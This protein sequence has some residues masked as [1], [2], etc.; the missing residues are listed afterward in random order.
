MM[1]GKGDRMKLATTASNLSTAL[2]CLRG[3]IERRNTIPILGAVK[4]EA[5]K[6]VGTNLD[7]EAEV[8]LPC[9][10]KP[11]GVAAIDYFSLVRLAGRIDADETVTI[12]EADDLAS[13]AFNGSEYSLPSLSAADFPASRAVE[14]AR[15]LTHNA[16][17]VAAMRRVRFA[18]ST[19]ETRYYLNGVSI[20]NDGDGNPVLAATDGHRLAMLPLPFAPDGSIGSIIHAGVVAWL[21]ARKGEPKAVT[22][23]AEWPAVKFEY[24]GLTLGAK[25]IDGTYPDI[26][27]VIPRN[28]LEYLSVDRRAM[29]VVLRRIASFVETARAVRIEAADGGVLLTVKAGERAAREFVSAEVPTP[30]CAGFNCRYLIDALSAFTAERVSFAAAPKEAAG[31]PSLITAADDP[32]RVV[33]MPMRV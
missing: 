21:C 16:G 2:K 22:F 31:S 23:A 19:E 17:L 30:F 26:F 5:G 33:V 29:L 1:P 13:I 20:L 3:V 32:L 11:Q 25:L 12:D 10:G 6:L 7:M 18:I 15:T 24:D 9:V 28:A 27:R 8:A 4:F 14:G